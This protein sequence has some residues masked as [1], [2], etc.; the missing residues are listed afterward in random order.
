MWV[1]VNGTLSKP[2]LAEESPPEPLRYLTCRLD[3]FQQQADESFR[4]MHDHG[5]MIFEVHEFGWLDLVVFLLPTGVSDGAK[6]FARAGLLPHILL[7]N[8]VG[9][10]GCSFHI[11]CP[12]DDPSSKVQGKHFA[13]VTTN[14]RIGGDLR[15][16]ARDDGTASAANAIDD[17]VI[18]HAVFTCCHEILIL[19]GN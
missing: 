14:G 18:T 3:G 10:C 12:E 19:V 2:L 7:A 17:L 1:L 8:E 11:G 6:R 9:T 16:H 15:L 5:M 13:L 4:R